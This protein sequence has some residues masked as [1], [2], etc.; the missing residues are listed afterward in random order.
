MPIHHASVRSTSECILM[1][2]LSPI[3]AHETNMGRQPFS[4]IGVLPSQWISTILLIDK[5]RSSDPNGVTLRLNLT[6]SS[7]CSLCL[8]Q[9]A[10]ALEW[11][12]C[13]RATT[14]IQSKGLNYC[15]VAENHFAIWSFFLMI[16]IQPLHLS[17][18]SIQNLWWGWLLDSL[19]WSIF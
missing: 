7:C 6:L 11:Q 17:V 12:S 16:F 13:C 19:S 10:L 2:T 18:Y 4:D 3:H 1:R 14:S 9:I 8:N 5:K 15:W